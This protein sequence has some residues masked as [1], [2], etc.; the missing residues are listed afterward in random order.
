[1]PR[2]DCHCHRP[3]VLLVHCHLGEAV[4]GGRAVMRSGSP[5]PPARAPLAVAS[6]YWWACAAP[7]AA[8]APCAAG[9]GG[10]QTAPWAY[11]LPSS[12]S[13]A[14]PWAPGL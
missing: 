2:L 13:M 7:E 3:W 5:L 12:G 9:R 1:M 6:T 14:N 8:S 10:L 11:S 4:A